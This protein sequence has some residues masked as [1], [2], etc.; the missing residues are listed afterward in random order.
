MFFDA[1]HV[2]RC[3]GLIGGK[4]IV[5]A[6]LRDTFAVTAATW[7]RRECRFPK[8][9]CRLLAFFASFS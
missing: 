6:C 7:L 9:N 4:S 8:P 2:K 5:L 1:P 3:K